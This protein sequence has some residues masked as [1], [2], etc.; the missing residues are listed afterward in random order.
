MDCVILNRWRKPL[1]AANCN[2]I[3]NLFFCVQYYPLN[4]SSLQKAKLTQ[5]NVTER[6]VCLT[7]SFEQ[8]DIF[9]DIPLPKRS[10]WKIHE[11]ELFIKTLSRTLLQI[12]AL[13]CCYFHKY[14]R[15]RQHSSSISP[16][17]NGL[18][19]RYRYL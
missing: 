17:R 15:F 14:D 18:S 7:H 13:F 2:K 10:G 1:E 3:I 19:C 6:I 4:P 8:P 9:E 12:N 16:G 11:G 5:V